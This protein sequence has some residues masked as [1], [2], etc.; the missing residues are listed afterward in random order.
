MEKIYKSKEFAPMLGV[1]VI[2]LQ[3]WDNEDKLEAH[4][5]PKGRGYY[6]ETQYREY[7]GIPKENKVGKTILYSR[8]SNQSQRKI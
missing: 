5:N 8:V 7:M 3:R 1:S 4:R 6:N 2:S